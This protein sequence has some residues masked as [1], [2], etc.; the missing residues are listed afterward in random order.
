M[1]YVI[2]AIIVIAAAAGWY[3]W[4]QQQ[5]KKKAEEE[6]RARIVPALEFVQHTSATHPERWECTHSFAE[7]LRELGFEV[8]EIPLEFGPAVTRQRTD[9]WDYD[10]GTGSWLSTAARLDPDVLL[11]AAYHS[12][13]IVEKG[14]N[15]GG[16][17]NSQ[18]DQLIEQQRAEFDPVE[19]QKL[20]YQIQ[21]LVAQDVPTIPLYGHKALQFV[22]KERF[23]NWVV[24]PGSD[25]VN[26]I[27]ITEIVPLTSDK[28]VNIGSDEP[29]T[30]FS[31]FD[32]SAQIRV[33][34]MFLYGRIA[35][36]SPDG[37]IVPDHA[38]SWTSIDDT[39]IEVVLR[40]GLTF[41]DGEELNADDVVFT[42]DYIFE[43]EPP[44]YMGL[45]ASLDSVTKVDDLT[46]RFNLKTPSATIYSGAFT[47]VPILP[48]HIWEDIPESMGLDH[49][50]EYVNDMPVGS[51]PMKM[52]QWVVGGS[53]V[54]ET[55]DDYWKP[56][57]VEGAVF[58]EHLNIE[59]KFLS[60]K[61]KLIDAMIEPLSVTLEA[62][63]RALDYIE[64]IEI[65]DIG[66]PYV[67]FNIRR[68]PGKDPNFRKAVVYAYDWD[69]ATDVVWRGEAYTG[70]GMIARTNQF[71]HNPDTDFAE[72]FPFDLAKAR[73]MLADAGY[74]WDAQGR[75]LY[76]KA[77]LPELQ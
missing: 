30:D 76:P 55:F 36:Y 65:L 15:M 24:I 2:I 38:E 1:T 28:V 12:S 49:P 71:W 33:D 41:H 66:V 62:E 54:W 72:R 26:Q 11:S 3:Y 10:I 18:V 57:N 37:S 58:V 23:S 5:Q 53:V 67:M 56:I 27:S 60:L 31:P 59:S 70:S 39:T 20:V 17:V 35:Q 69:Y 50:D 14:L 29:R 45:V 4:D 61:A 16:Y 9:G 74:E 13:Q 44:V 8:T 52:V 46:V 7:S 51:G 77:L 19:R 64:E 34:L 48:E 47:L 22:N 43:W 75:I 68:Y 40:D 73:Q 25:L 32:T 42:Y 63:A 21:E 6:L